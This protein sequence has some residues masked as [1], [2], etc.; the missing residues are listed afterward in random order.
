LIT[1]PVGNAQFANQ[2]VKRFLIGSETAAVITGYTTTTNSVYNLPTPVGLGAY[3]TLSA[4]TTV[5][6]ITQTIT[7]GMYTVA[8]DTFMLAAGNMIQTEAGAQLTATNLIALAGGG[9]NLS[10]NFTNIAG[11]LRA[12]DASYATNAVL[13]GGLAATGEFPIT[14]ASDL[15]VK[16]LTDN[17]HLITNSMTTADIIAAVLPPP[18]QSPIPPF[19][20]YIPFQDNCET[21]AF[22]GSEGY[23]RTAV[24]RFA[25]TEVGTYELDASGNRA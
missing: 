8:G 20:P 14:S 3:S 2:A 1:V 25:L 24:D 17:Y 11:G 23:V 6:G 18:P 10:G 21:N 9:V 4:T 12:P 5:G 13:Q 16:S 22:I 19:E 7:P 15:Y